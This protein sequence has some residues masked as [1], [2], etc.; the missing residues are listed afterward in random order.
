MGIDSS[1]LFLLSLVVLPVVVTMITRNVELTILT[2]GANGAI[3]L[4]IQA[5]QPNTSVLWKWGFFIFLVVFIIS[6]VDVVKKTI[7]DDH[8]KKRVTQYYIEGTTIRDD[9]TMANVYPKIST[10]RGAFMGWTNKIHKDIQKNRGRV[11]ES[12]FMDKNGIRNLASAMKG[13]MLRI[14]DSMKQ[15]KKRHFIARIV[16]L[17]L[18]HLKEL[19]KRL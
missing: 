4:G 6:L 15:Q 14:S 8:F 19:Q 7:N 11:E 3:I 18:E 2:I 5:M 12:F 9:Q 10:Y 17:R 16:E 13:E 1:I